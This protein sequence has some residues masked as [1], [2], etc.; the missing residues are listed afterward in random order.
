MNADDPHRAHSD[1]AL[2]QGSVV[3][4][5]DIW[6]W[7]DDRDDD[8]DRIAGDSD[9][10]AGAAEDVIDIE[11]AR[12]IQ[13]ARAAA[14]EWDDERWLTDAQVV[15]HVDDDGPHDGSR[16]VEADDDEGTEA[17]GTKVQRWGTTTMLGAS[18]SGLGIGL[19]QVLRPKE[20]IPIEIEV[21]DR[22][23][24]DLDPIEVRLGKDP[25][26]SVAL[27][28]P[29]LQGRSGRSDAPEGH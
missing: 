4:G 2:P 5:A 17:F 25:D 8:R 1:A 3:P 15:A 18:L 9:V 29:W 24:D 13:D 23:D 28:R 20:A 19:Q 11:T 7:D 10:G 27:L 22:T 14:A 6:D 16:G 26:H 21:D 12:Q